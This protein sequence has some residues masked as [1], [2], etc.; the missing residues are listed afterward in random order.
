[1]K[2]FW[3][4]GEP[5]IWLTG[6]TLAFCIIMIGGLVFLIMLKGLGI[7]WPAMLVQ[8][9]LKD[10]SQLMGQI[11]GRE[12]IPQLP[13][14]YRLQLKIGNRDLYGLDFKWVK[15][16]QILKQT[17]TDE[18]F[19]FER[20][21]WG[22]LYGFIKE[23][24]Q[25]EQKRS[26]SRFKLLLKETQQLY[27]RIK[28]IEKKEI[29]DINYNLEKLRLKIR[30]LQLKGNLDSPYTKAQLQKLNH[31][32]QEQKERYNQ[33]EEEL[34]ILYEKAAQNKIVVATIDGRIKEIPLFYIVRAYQPNVMSWWEKFGLYISKLWEFIA[35]DPREANTE[36]G[37]FPA[38]FGTVMM[39]FI[40]SFATMPLGVVAALYLR[41]YAKEG[42]LVR[43]VRISVNNLAG[44]PSIVFGVFG[45]GFFIYFIGGTIDQV[46]FSEALPA[47]T[48]GTGG[49]LWASL[50]LALLTVPVVIVTTEEG[51]A[52]IPMTLREAS[53]AL[54]ATKWQTTWR[55]LLPSAMPAILTGMILAIAR[56][57]GE[58]APLMI[59][60][61]VKLAPSLPLDKH[62]P[63]IHPE[64][65]FMHLG[66][67][68]YDVGF[69]SP[70]VEAAKPMVYTTTLLLIVI[71]ICLNLTAI[72]IRNKLRKKYTTAA[73]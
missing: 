46:F 18:A 13:D 52:S 71:I 36:G 55:V 43:I 9:T 22:N 61:V 58:V 45:L 54:G 17:Y 68:I 69:Q 33:K 56:A 19:V 60:G 73:F 25:G 30:E 49:I 15:E 72:I 53:L 48:F 27:Q 1:M 14:H 11:I 50:T 64:R 7:F 40:M 51:L 38:I 2:N 37:I 3:K 42:L 41:E 12:E 8:L 20:L 70:N 63:F 32:I 62:F 57:T 34:R 28:S 59:T 5:F 4:R 66:F 29:G 16:D 47:P 39:V 24:R 23:L 21:E 26:R 35:G 6:G 31:R 10:G 65:K 67:H 44:V